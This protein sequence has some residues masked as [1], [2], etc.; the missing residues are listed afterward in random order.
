MSFRSTGALTVSA[1]VFASSA[2]LAVD[3]PETEANDT[4][5]AANPVVLVG[6][7]DTL[8][9]TTTGSS[10]TAA[11]I[12]S[13]DNFRLTTPTQV[14]GIY[15]NRLTLTT[16]G[17]VGHTGTIRG[18]TQ[19]AT[20][21]NSIGPGTINAGTDSTVQTSST[22]TTPARFNQF[23]TFG[24]STQFVYRV[25]GTTSTTAPYA[26]TWT[27]ESV[28]PISLGAFNPG[29]YVFTNVGLASTQD[30]EVLILDSNFQVVGLNDDAL[31]TANGGPAIPGTS[32]VLNSYLPINLSEGVY[33]VAISNFNIATSTA[34]TANEG[35]ADASVMDFAGIMANSSTSTL[36]S[37][38][39]SFSHPGGTS[40]FTATKPGAFDV[41]FGTLTVIP[42]PA[43][44]TLV[45]AGSLL[46]LRRKRA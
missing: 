38:P 18:L 13:A 39:F 27:Q 41:W 22:A 42:E 36:A 25:A 9:G 32:S 7:G 28:T 40:N 35:S 1:V 44:L 29:S 2:V 12:G 6:P 15:R 31:D 33:Y 8:S 37:I 4:K 24:P 45:A 23:Y 17:T 11:G 30:T 34:S 43:T 46:A 14:A 3:F 5:A 16:S 19:T 20:G 21:P 10:T 26:S